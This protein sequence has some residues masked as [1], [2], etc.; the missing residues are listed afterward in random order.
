ME[1]NT[2]LCLQHQIV[3]HLKLPIVSLWNMQC[4]A[5]DKN[6]FNDVSAFDQ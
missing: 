6:H 3:D 1:I 5:E 4:K 2:F